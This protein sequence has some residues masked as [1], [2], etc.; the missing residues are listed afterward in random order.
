LGVKKTQNP[1]SDNGEERK[2]TKKKNGVQAVNEKMGWR[3]DRHHV[4][5]MHTAFAKRDGIREGRKV[6][7]FKKKKKKG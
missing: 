1:V 4:K 6:W 2:T 7:E 3:R 5:E